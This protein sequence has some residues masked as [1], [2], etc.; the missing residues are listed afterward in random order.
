MTKLTVSLSADDYDS[1]PPEVRAYV[2]D[3]HAR[4]E[5]DEK[6]V[7]QLRTQL[8]GCGVAALGGTKPEVTAKRGDYGWSPAYQDVLNLRFKLEAQLDALGKTAR[9]LRIERHITD[10]AE[11]FEALED[12]AVGEDIRGTMDRVL[13]ALEGHALESERE[14]RAAEEMA[15]TIMEHPLFNRRA[16]ALVVHMPQDDRPGFSYCGQVIEH[17]NPGEV[18]AAWGDADCVVCLHY[19]SPIVPAI[20][21][22]S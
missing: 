22:D 9:C 21:R 8:A 2:D 4:H 15:A 11:L 12:E 14:R 20:L 7:E 18:A 13:E 1:L 3:L 16:A 10:V 17:M 19:R 6:E 5:A